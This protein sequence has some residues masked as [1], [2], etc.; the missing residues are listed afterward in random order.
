F[1]SMTMGNAWSFPSKTMSYDTTLGAMKALAERIARL[2]RGYREP[3]HPIDMNCA[4]EPAYLKAAAEVSKEL[5]LAEAIPKLC[6]LVTAS[7]FDAAVHDA[8]GKAFGVSSYATYSDAY[9]PHDLPHYLGADYKGEY[10][11]RYVLPEP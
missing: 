6:V 5:K 2:T 4:L 10:L 1:G 8:Y 7:P 11:S 9:M 3:G